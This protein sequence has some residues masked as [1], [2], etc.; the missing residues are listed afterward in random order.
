[1]SSLAETRTK[2]HVDDENLAHCISWLTAWHQVEGERAWDFVES[3]ISNADDR[4]E[5]MITLC[6]LLK[7]PFGIRLPL[8]VADYVKPKTLCTIFS[9]LMN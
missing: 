3:L 2:A 8:A 9:C 6:A 5:L 7:E 1:M 4:Q